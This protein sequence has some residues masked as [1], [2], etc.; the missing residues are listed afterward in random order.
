MY[1]EVYFLISICLIFCTHIL[2]KIV[3]KIIFWRPCPYSKWLPIW[4]QRSAAIIYRDGTATT[5]EIFFFCRWLSCATHTFAP[6]SIGPTQNINKWLMCVNLGTPS[7]RRLRH[8]DSRLVD[9][10]V[11]GDTVATASI[12]LHRSV[13]CSAPPRTNEGWTCQ[14]FQHHQPRLLHCL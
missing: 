8:V 2:V 4:Y 10:G 7:Q 5:G 6:R 9:S 11:S 12:T 14:A 1:T 3:V 13:T